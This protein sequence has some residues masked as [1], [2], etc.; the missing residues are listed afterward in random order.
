MKNTTS[1]NGIRKKIVVFGAGKIGRSFIGQLFSA[2]GYEVIFIDKNEQLIKELNKRNNYNVVIK[3]DSEKII[4]VSNVRGLNLQQTEDI[5]NEI[6]STEIMAV[7]SGPAGLSS[8]L[9]LIS[10]GLKKRAGI[11][12]DKALDIIVAE[13]LR[14]ASLYFET[15]LK[16]LL[17]ENFPLKNTV[18]L[19]E[20]SIGKMVPI[21]SRKDIGE[22][23]LQ[24]FA[25][26]YNTLILDKQGFL[27]PIPD[28]K[29]LAPKNNIKAWV[30]CKLFIHNLGHASCAYLGYL[31]N[32]DLVFVYEALGIPE[33]YN[34]VRSTMLQSARVLLKKYPDDFTE[35]YLIE[36]IDDLLYRFC[37]KSLGDTIFRVGCDLYRKLGPE[38]RIAGCIKLAMELNLPY[39]RVL[40]ILLCACRFKARD[41]EGN[42][43][44]SDLDF[45]NNYK[46]NTEKILRE[47]CGFDPENNKNFFE[48]AQ[49]IDLK[50]RKADLI[51]CI[52]YG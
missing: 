46:G 51:H 29:G 32:P 7:S 6:S 50:L 41:E 47:V 10:E 39:D 22:D 3:G 43:L 20:T 17:P 8:A 52:R 5:I 1:G 48:E 38:D 34:M 36:H 31:Y 49:R 24:I 37:N 21:M 15:E 45:S 42:P 16:K 9:Y 18:G 14:N 33:I 4:N 35:S 2:G 26:A 44:K 13:N 30:D 19:I 11:L 25:E 12:N 28:I 27:N 23:T 40:T